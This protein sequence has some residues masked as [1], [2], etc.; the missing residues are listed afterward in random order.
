[1]ADGPLLGATVV[2]KG[3]TIGVNTD[4]NGRFTFPKKLKENDVLLVT[5]LGYKNS[6]I[7]IEDDTTYVEPYLKDNPVIIRTAFRTKTNV[8]TTLKE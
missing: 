4:E 6:E 8:P 1:S 7:I 3:T 2:L 5:F